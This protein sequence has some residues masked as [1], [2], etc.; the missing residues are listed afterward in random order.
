MFTYCTPG[1]PVAYSQIRHLACHSTWHHAD[2]TNKQKIQ[3]RTP[4]SWLLVWPENSLR[5]HSN[6]KKLRQHLMPPHP[7]FWAQDPRKLSPKI[8]FLE[9]ESDFTLLW[10]GTWGDVSINLAQKWEEKVIRVCAS[11]VSPPRLIPWFP[12]W[13]FYE[14]PGFGSFSADCPCCQPNCCRTQNV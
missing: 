7:L 1:C 2:Y 9:T 6:M 14:I 12:L 8:T 10:E 13:H 3:K 11:V 4:P 5:L